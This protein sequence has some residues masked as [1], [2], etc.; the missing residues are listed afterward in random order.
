MKEKLIIAAITYSVLMTSA[1]A[2]ANP[3][4]AAVKTMKNGYDT[5]LSVESI[6]TEPEKLK[7][8]K[9]QIDSLYRQSPNFEGLDNALLIK[10]G[11][12]PEDTDP[13]ELNVSTFDIDGDVDAGYKITV[14]KARKET[15][16]QFIKQLHTTHFV[17]HV[18]IYDNDQKVESCQ[19]D[20]FYKMGNNTMVF[21]QKCGL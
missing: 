16:L 10:A 6:I 11:Y 21:I 8:L 12:L 3:V 15:C 9:V 14:S 2:F 4:T 5:Q 7:Y 17:K 1:S 18:E 20:S 13:S 19:N